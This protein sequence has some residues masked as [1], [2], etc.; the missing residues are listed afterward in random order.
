MKDLVCLVA[1]KSIEA[2]VDGMLQRPEALGIRS[3]SYETV[4]HPRRDPGCF[5]DAPELLS[6][7]VDRASHALVV[8]DRAWDGAPDGSAKELELRLERALAGM[9]H[10]DWARAVVIDPEL[11]NWVFVDSPHVPAELWW[12]GSMATMRDALEAEGLWAAGSPKPTDPKSAV[13][14]VLFRARRPLSSSIYR[15]LASKVS[16]A[17][18][19]DRSF[20][21][22]KGLL[23][24]WFG[25]E[26]PVA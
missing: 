23:R 21:R 11:E 1:D 2:A 13:K 14:W 12:Q 4:V 16:L 7:Y 18:C 6:G 8:L 3:L 22:L 20:L 10:G 26:A 5:H 17:K 15:A 9:G 19:V 24:D 25:N